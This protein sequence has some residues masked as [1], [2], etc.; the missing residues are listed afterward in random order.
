MLQILDG[1]TERM[2]TQRTLVQNLKREMKSIGLQNVGFP[3]GNM[4]LRMYSAGENRLFFTYFKTDGEGGTE[5]YWNAFGFFD[6]KRSS[7][8]ITVE[9]N[10]AVESQTQQVAAFYARDTDTGRDYLLHSGKV[11]GGY[12]GVGRNAFL[13]WSKNRLVPTYDGVG[14]AARLGILLGPVDDDNLAN[15]IERFVR[16]VADFKRAVREKSIDVDVLAPIS[17]EI[18]Q[19]K[20]EFAGRKKGKRSSLD[21]DYLCK[22]GEVVDGLQADRE[23]RKTASEIVANNGYID[24]YVKD[25]GSLTE[26]Y[27][28]KTSVERQPLYTAIGQL[29]V[30]GSQPEAPILHLVVPRDDLLPDDIRIA[31]THHGIKTV[32]F[33]QHSSGYYEFF[34]E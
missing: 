17:E 11:G 23:A 4:T 3:G 32:R 27:E 13:A 28:I 24:L 34:E 6:S 33:R 1:K 16:Q 18:E 31:L 22:H 19:F 2:R 15:R 5:R 20:S 21:I 7:H 12:E 10:I 14:R 25:H 8:D 26:I 29:I 9:I 30:H